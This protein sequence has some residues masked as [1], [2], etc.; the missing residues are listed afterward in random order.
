MACGARGPALK[1]RLP[2]AILAAAL[3][4]GTGAW[5]PAVTAHGPPSQGTYVT[6]AM[7]EVKRGPGPQYETIRTLA[8]GRT[9]E[10]VG[11]QGRWLQ[12]RLSEHDRGDGYIDERFA[13]ARK[14][15]H[16]AQRRFPIPGSYLTTAPADVRIG[17]GEQ[18][19]IVS[20]IPAGTR[21]VVVGMEANWL[22]LAA[23]RGEPPGY[24]ERGQGRLQPAE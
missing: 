14:P 4:A 5:P 1:R 24:I 15:D 6:T 20:T 21:I 10:I 22:R 13:V 3:V 8:K 18:H 23:K 9:F 16:D 12:V 11:K 19:A 17:P 2:A 7:V